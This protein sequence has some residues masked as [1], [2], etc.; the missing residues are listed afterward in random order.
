MVP[1]LEVRMTECTGK[2]SRLNHYPFSSVT[3]HHL[4]H[5]HRARQCPGSSTPSI[6]LSVLD[7]TC[8]VCPSCFFNKQL[9]AN[10]DA[11]EMPTANGIFTHYFGK[12]ADWQGWTLIKCTYLPPSASAVMER[13]DFVLFKGKAIDATRGSTC[14]PEAT[15]EL[16]EMAPF[17]YS[18]CGFA[19]R[20]G[21]TM[22]AQDC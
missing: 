11:E 21:N 16:T 18:L 1:Q 10:R 15:L 17:A 3:S 13:G 22:P 12:N 7:W 19:L 8:S 4:Y 20:L 9:I 14:L 2:Y 5:H 6:S